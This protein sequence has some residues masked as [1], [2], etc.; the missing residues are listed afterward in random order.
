MAFTPMQRTLK[1][2]RARTVFDM[3]P[4]SYRGRDVRCKGGI[5]TS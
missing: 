5:Q 1:S 3:K 4:S 2:P